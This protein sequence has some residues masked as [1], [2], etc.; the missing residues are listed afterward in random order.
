MKDTQQTDSLGVIYFLP[1][2]PALLLQRF[3]ED[4]PDWKPAS[5]D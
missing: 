2:D 3:A 4:F 5:Q 1:N